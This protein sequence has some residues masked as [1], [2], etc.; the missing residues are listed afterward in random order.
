MDQSHPLSMKFPNIENMMLKSVPCSLL[1][2]SSQA[3][4]FTLDASEQAASH[5]PVNWRVSM[6]SQQSMPCSLLLLSSQVLHFTRNASEQAASHF[7]VNWRVLMTSQQL[8]QNLLVIFSCIHVLSPFLLFF[9][10]SPYVLDGDLYIAVSWIKRK[11]G[12]S[13]KGTKFINNFL[14]WL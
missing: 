13:L 4:H 10:P 12:W 9:W 5:F 14:I 11:A 8:Y 1:L 2:L 6:T 3:L 7:P